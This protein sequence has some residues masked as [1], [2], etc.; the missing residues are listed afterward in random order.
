MN[1]MIRL[2][3][4][5]ETQ[6]IPTPI[7]YYTVKI[8]P[9]IAKD[10]IEYRD[11]NRTLKKSNITYIK[12]CMSKND[13]KL[14]GEPIVFDESGFLVNGN[15]RLEVSAEYGYTFEST[16]I[17]GIKKEDAAIYDMQ[18]KR[19][20][21]DALQFTYSSNDKMYSANATSL[22]NFLLSVEKCVVKRKPITGI[23]AAAAPLNEYMR[24]IAEYNDAI[25]FTLPYLNGASR[26]K[27]LGRVAVWAAVFTAFVSG[28]NK[29]TLEKWCDV[30]TNGI[31][32]RECDIPVI[33]FRDY[34]MG[35][36]GKGGSQE[37]TMAVF[38]RAQYSLA[39]YETGN[40][41]AMNKEC[42]VAY[43]DLKRTIN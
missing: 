4:I 42:S 21:S 18:A 5:L 3:A 23:R 27:G 34:V 17:V 25:L 11:F 10:L 6:S 19:R 37:T 38:S 28:Y 26:T 8:T 7:R 35:L 9:E 22:Y 13:W 41:K 43:Y 14:N 16:V 2:L 32:Q 40:S 33:K 30:F 39:Q 20:V 36:K 31:V 12:D 29:E 1:K 24:F 15:H